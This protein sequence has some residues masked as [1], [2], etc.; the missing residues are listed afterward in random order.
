M[1]FDIELAVNLH[2]LNATWIKLV[3]R[4]V[5]Y[6]TSRCGLTSH[7][8]SP[9]TL[10]TAGPTAVPQT[11]SII[12]NRKTSTV[13]DV[14]GLKDKHHGSMAAGKTGVNTSSIDGA[15]GSQVGVCCYM[16]EVHFYPSAQQFFNDDACLWILI[17]DMM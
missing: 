2:L 14:K 15:T 8:P 17:L 1:Y 4:S 10:F 16:M 9:L 7:W 6:C 11:Q 5:N 3:D 12:S 13:S